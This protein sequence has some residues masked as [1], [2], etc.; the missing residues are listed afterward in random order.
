MGRYG[1]DP[2]VRSGVATPP[3]YLGLPMC[4]EVGLLYIHHAHI[5]IDLA[6]RLQLVQTAQ[7][8]G[9]ICSPGRTVASDGRI[10]QASQERH[11]ARHD[12]RLI[13]RAMH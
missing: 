11:Y 5:H 2:A 10:A 8:F 12:H 1:R 6:S 7:R 3:F 13:K 4:G 9:G